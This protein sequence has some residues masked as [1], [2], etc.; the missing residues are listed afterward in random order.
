V[1]IAFD[2]E[3]SALFNALLAGGAEDVMLGL[4]DAKLASDFDSRKTSGVSKIH[5]ILYKGYTLPAWAII[6]DNIKLFSKLTEKQATGTR[7]LDDK[8]NTSL[9]ISAMYGTPAA[10]EIMMTSQ[11]VLLEARNLFGKTAIMQSMKIGNFSTLRY[12]AKNVAEPRR[13]LEEQY[14]AWLL[15]IC[16]RRERFEKTLQT[17]KIQIDDETICPMSPDPD[18]LFWYKPW[19]K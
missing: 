5:D 12:L 15:Q 9:H 7:G 11:K 17:G 19:E 1:C 8:G 13:G 2:G 3:D 10:L 4:K 6:L 14:D 16:R 18:Y